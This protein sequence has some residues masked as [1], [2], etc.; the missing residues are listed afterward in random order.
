MINLLRVI[1]FLHS[2]FAEAVPGWMKPID[3]YLTGNISLAE[4]ILL[5]KLVINRPNIFNQ[6]DI[7]AKHLLFYLCEKQTGGKFIHYFYRDVLKQFINFVPLMKT[8]KPDPILV[9]KVVIKLIR[10]LPYEDINV[11]TD[12]IDML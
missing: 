4:R 9:S 8:E 5:I 2:N 11:Y 3:T 10:S 6:A 12:N 7:W 1:D